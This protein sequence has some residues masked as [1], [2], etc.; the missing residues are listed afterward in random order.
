LS[1]DDHRQYIQKVRQLNTLSLEEEYQLAKDWREK[2]DHK[3]MKKLAEAH[4]KLVAKVAS[5][6]RGYGLPISDLIAE[7]N[8]G[9][10]QAMKHYEPDKG[11]RF[12]TYAMW[13]IKASMQ[14]YILHTWSLVKIGTTAAQKKLF[15]SLKKTKRE[16]INQTDGATQ[17]EQLTKELVQKIATKLNVSEDEVWSMEQRIGSKDAS[18]H[19]PVG[20]GERTAEWMDWLADESDNQEIQLVQRDEMDKRRQA[21]NKAMEALNAREQQI[22]VS[23]RL[24][25]P[26]KTLEEISQKLDISRERVRQLEFSAFEK[27]KKGLQ[28]SRL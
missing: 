13:W 5:G 20:D 10:M 24:E 14:D 8:I 2:Q 1:Q 28:H 25:E 18:L 4:L 16:I 22:L 19:T 3:A 21:F 7:G 27:L 9:M 26:P 6:Y 11:F 12:S 17:E 23:R 15:F